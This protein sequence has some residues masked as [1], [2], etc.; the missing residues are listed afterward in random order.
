MAKFGSTYTGVCYIG[1]GANLNPE[2]NILRG[3]TRLHRLY[4]L[5]GISNFYRSKAIDRTEQPD[6]L[7]G[8]VAVQYSGVV[9]VLKYDVLRKIEAQLGRERTKDAYA[10]RPIDFDIIL[11]DSMILR[12][13]GLVVPDPDIRRRPFLVA[14]LLDLDPS[15]ALPDRHGALKGLLKS[16]AL[17]QLQT[18]RSFSRA[19]KERFLK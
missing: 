1:V 12:E 18:A 3:L 8:I 10:A 7:N 17:K 13:P 5:V 15:V 16:P 11:C 9:R 6:Y 14:A 19:L 2:S 4:P